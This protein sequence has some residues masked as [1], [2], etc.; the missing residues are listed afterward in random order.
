MAESPKFLGYRVAHTDNGN[1]L[2]GLEFEG[3]EQPTPIM[4]FT[5]QGAIALADEL[6]HAADDAV[7]A[8]RASRRG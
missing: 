2:I 1:V 3:Q 8:S 6:M 5:P 4:E 7:H